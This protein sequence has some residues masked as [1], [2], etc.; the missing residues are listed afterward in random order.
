MSIVVSPRIF[1]SVLTT[2]ELVIRTGSPFSRPLATSSHRPAL[3]LNALLSCM[4][5]RSSRLISTQLYVDSQPSASAGRGGAGGG[6]PG[7]GCRPRRARPPARLFLPEALAALAAPP[8]L[9][10]VG[11]LPQS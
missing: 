5:F 1:S 4:L 6:R 2:G 9:L 10:F 11:T 3:S 7:R 8:P